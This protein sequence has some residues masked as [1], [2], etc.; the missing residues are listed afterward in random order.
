MTQTITDLAAKSRQPAPMA[1]MLYTSMEWYAARPQ[2]AV[3][4]LVVRVWIAQASKL[5]QQ[6]QDVL[7]GLVELQ[8]ETIDR[9]NQTNT[10][11]K[12]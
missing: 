1:T 5:I 12:E 7:C 11:P 9:H 4:P 6:Y 3:T 10:N 8:V 2:A